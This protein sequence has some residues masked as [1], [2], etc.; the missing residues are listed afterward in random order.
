MEYWK[1]A[2]TENMSL[3]LQNGNIHKSIQET[4]IGVP[5]H[6]PKWPHNISSRDYPTPPIED[7]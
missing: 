5:A 3:E 2:Y 7:S 4:G 1:L 6:L